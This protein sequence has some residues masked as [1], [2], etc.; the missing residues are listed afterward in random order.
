MEAERQEEDKMY[1][2]SVQPRR[3]RD[4]SPLNEMHSLR[5]TH[6]SS[7]NALNVS[8]TRSRRSDSSR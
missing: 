7:K 1:L 4:E 8:G 2:R 6:H 3:P 5:V